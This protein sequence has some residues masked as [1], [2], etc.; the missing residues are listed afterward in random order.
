MASLVHLLR[1]PD[2]VSREPHR[3]SGCYVVTSRPDQGLLRSYS[4]YCPLRGVTSTTEKR[5]CA[6]SVVEHLGTGAQLASRMGGWRDAPT[7]STEPPAR[8]SLPSKTCA[9]TPTLRLAFTQRMATASESVPNPWVP[10]HSVPREEG[11]GFFFS[12]RSGVQVL[13]VRSQVKQLGRNHSATP[14]TLSVL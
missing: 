2:I 4:R 9:A 13:S 7:T 11:H 12:F 6:H 8:K 3:P 1:G 10:L 5:M 14:S